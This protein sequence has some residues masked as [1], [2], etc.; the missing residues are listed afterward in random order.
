MYTMYTKSWISQCMIV[1]TIINSTIVYTLDRVYT[2][3]DTGHVAIMNV[4]YSID[5]MYRAAKKDDD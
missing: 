4:R 1:T 2:L 3:K 5:H